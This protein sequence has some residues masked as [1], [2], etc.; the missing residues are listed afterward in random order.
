VLNEK[1]SNKRERALDMGG[2]LR[3]APTVTTLV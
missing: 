3:L 2:M 1:R